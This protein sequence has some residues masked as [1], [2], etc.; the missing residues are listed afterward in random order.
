[1]ELGTPQNT[2]A[3]HHGAPRRA[4][5]GPHGP[6]SSANA[7]LVGRDE[8][9]HQSRRQ[10]AAGR[11]HLERRQGCQADAHVA[12]TFTCFWGTMKAGDVAVADLGA[13]VSEKI[14]GLIQDAGALRVPRR[15][16]IAACLE[17]QSN[18]S[19]AWRSDGFYC[20]TRK[21]RWGALGTNGSR[22]RRRRNRW[23]RMPARRRREHQHSSGTT[24]VHKACCTPARGS[25]SASAYA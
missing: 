13:A 5:P 16:A 25:T 20:T 9:R 7:R 23:C 22:T 1:M 3:R 8:P 12:R 2:I 18:R 6:S 4:W 11:R 21:R 15:G 19:S 17:P 24:G 10:P 14:A